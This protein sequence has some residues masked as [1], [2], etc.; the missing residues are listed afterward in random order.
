MARDLK[1]TNPPRPKAG[2]DVIAAGDVALVS[3][4]GLVDENFAGFG[5]LGTMK[6]VVINVAGMTRMTS[7]GVRQWLKGMDALPKSIGDLYLIGCPTFFVDQLNMVLNFG[8]AAQI[9]TVV[10][11]YTCPSCGSESG[12][13][14][15]VLV[16]RAAL[17]K[18]GVSEK[19]CSKCGGKLE[20]DETPESYFS[21][22]NKYAASSIQPA[23]AQLLAS[24]GLYTAHDTAGE[25]PP[26]IIKLVHG[27]VTYFRII[28][29][30][31]SMFRARPFLVGAEGEVV[32]DLAEVATFT[33]VDVND[34]FLTNAGD[35]FGLAK[36]I[37]VWS[38]LVPYA[39]IDCGRVSAESQILDGAKWPLQFVPHVCS[40][41]GGTTRSEL[42]ANMLVPLQKAST[43]TP[44]ASAKLIGQRDEV[45]SRALT[46]ANVAQAGEG[47]T[48]SLIADDTILGK[49]KIVRR[50]SAGGM[51]EVFLAKQIGIGGF[52]KPV[53]LKRIQRQLLESRH[54]A[55]D[56][57]L[58]EAKI[59][60]RLMHPNIVQVLDV[61]EVS[62][63]LYLAMEYV[64]GKDLRDV[65]KKLR[66]SRTTM[67][68]GEAC[69][70]V[71][72]VAQALHHAYW[73]T[74]MA[75]QR[76]NV[77]HR[78]VSPHNIIL[79][80]DGTVKLLDFG[81][82]MS[83]VTE[84]AETMIVGKWLYM[85]PEHTT[86]QALDHR[87]DLFSLGVILY[88]LCTGTMPFAGTEPKDIV[89]KIRAGQYKPLQVCAPNVP[90]DLALLVGRLL[91]PN[92]DERPQ[93]GHEVVAALTEITRNHGIESS[94]SNIASFLADM[95]ADDQSETGAMELVRSKRATDEM[96]SFTKKVAIGSGPT[97]AQAGAFDDSK[98]PSSFSQSLS[99]GAPAGR[100][101]PGGLLAVD[102]SVS[103]A[104]R[105][106]EFSTPPMP[107]PT[108]TQIQAPTPAPTPL[109]TPTLKPKHNPKQSF[110]APIPKLGESNWSVVLRSSI[111]VV[112]IVLLAVATYLFVRPQ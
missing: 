31:G 49:Y 87:S 48:A 84:Q 95:F 50:L 24:H 100:I 109:P 97:Q 13:T 69:F 92:P 73:S 108:I 47:A 54:L 2:V 4:A 41:C 51:A 21:F 35:S 26:R 74:D 62:G 105:S 72:E 86:N 76:L 99:S 1:P 61:G 101:T 52:E 11:P 46:D 30:I 112:L 68:L 65:V 40:K 43:S 94:P 19:A 10:A 36:N 81:V 44:P 53:A 33:L 59:A 90:E 71:R 104:R 15:D 67:P 60:G 78:D 77:V 111:I 27:A 38:V 106:H 64:R 32:I 5:S 91:A 75:G 66:A 96:E 14:I 82:A 110:A 6:T 80:Y 9:L 29:T 98:S 107:T 7:F 79:S 34:S 8:G 25:K 83:S 58:N 89:R 37:S 85:S 55:I 42:P 17:A 18:G 45:L 93:T 88:L 12:E 70:V 57:F 23:A 103:L 20:F 28:G 102:V 22:V 56:M 39:C 63:A 16:E 3:V